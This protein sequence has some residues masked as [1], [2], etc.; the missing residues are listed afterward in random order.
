MQ[1][2]KLLKKSSCQHKS[3]AGFTLVELLI[4]S[5]IGVLVIGA[6]G[7]G[8]MNLLRNSRS[9]TAQI[10][11][12]TE[13]NRAMEFI[14][15]E[16]RRADTIDVNPTTA[17][18]AAVTSPPANAQPV[19]ALNIPG[20]INPAVPGADSPIIYFVSSPSGDDSSVW[21]GPRVIYRFGPPSGIDGDFTGNTWTVEPLVD[22]ISEDTVTTDCDSGWTASPSSGAKGFYACVLPTADDPTLGET[23][24]IFAIGKLDDGN[25][26][27]ENY[28]ADTQVFARA[29]AENLDGLNPDETYTEACDFTTGVLICPSN[30]NDKTYTIENLS[31]AL[32][33]NPDGAL[34][35]IK[36]IAYSYENSTNPATETWLGEAT[37]TG[38]D[39]LNNFSVTSPLPVI[40]KVI[41]APSAPNNCTTNPFTP[42]QQNQDTPVASNDPNQFKLLD[43]DQ[44]EPALEKGYETSNGNQ[45]T[46]KDILNANNLID[47]IEPNKINLK[48]NQYVVAFEIGQTDTTHPGFD[49]ND[50]LLLI[51]VSE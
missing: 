49:T 38:T 26:Y 23:V 32:A 22:G 3:T 16:M 17:F 25:S 4:S 20:V 44:I 48:D 47:P 43:A 9:S 13:F 28:Q 8:L 40:F 34:W 6:A 35:P 30:G 7:Y 1:I 11:K 39:P 19:L 14:S 21:N 50:Q 33:C 46:A 41:P 42:T 15:D 24:K 18:N 5:F 29:E 45:D 2:N 36:I 27:S 12:R 37:A 10:Q 51:T 31:S